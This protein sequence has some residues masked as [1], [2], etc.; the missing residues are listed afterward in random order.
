[1]NRRQFLAVA[2]AT[3]LG[4]L[5]GCTGSGNP[6]ASSPESEDPSGTPSTSAGPTGSASTPAGPTGTPSP[7]LTTCTDPDFGAAPTVR[8]TANTSRRGNLTGFRYDVSVE[9]EGDGTAELAI[10]F[11]EPTGADCDPVVFERV[12][13]LRP[14]GQTVIRSP[15]GRDGQ[16]DLVA[17]VRDGQEAR[18]RVETHEGGIGSATAYVVRVSGASVSIDR[19]TA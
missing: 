12:Y 8:G 9:N 1:M 2:G 15:V 5:A 16:Y 13:A 7:A 11:A 3:V 14:D 19:Y 10:R 6:A 18:R 4:S 17:I